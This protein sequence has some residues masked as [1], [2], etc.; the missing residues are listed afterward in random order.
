MLLREWEKRRQA[1]ARRTI[2]PLVVAVVI[3]MVIA[4]FT[5]TWVLVFGF[6]LVAAFFA[7]TGWLAWRDMHKT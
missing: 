4:G 2:I 1:I 6:A 7:W 5:S 3:I